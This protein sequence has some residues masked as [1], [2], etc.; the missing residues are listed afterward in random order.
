MLD[1][2]QLE[3]LVES[4]IRQVA[5]TD[6]APEGT[7]VAPEARL[8]DMGLD[9]LDSVEVEIA[10]EENSNSLIRFDDENRVLPTDTISEIVSKAS[11]CQYS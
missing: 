6:L 1:R 3:E 10:I 7:P 11:T 9:S 2:R 8:V 4:A 5:G